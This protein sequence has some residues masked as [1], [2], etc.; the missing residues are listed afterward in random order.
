M[1]LFVGTGYLPMKIPNRA[2]L[3]YTSLTSKH[4]LY[5]DLW[6]IDFHQYGSV[7]VDR[8]RETLSAFFPTYRV[9]KNFW[10]LEILFYPV[11][12]LMRRHGVYPIHSGGVAHRGKGLVIAGGSGAGK[13]TLA[14]H[15]VR[16]G[17]EFLS[18]DRCL[19]HKENGHYQAVGIH[20]LARIYP[21]NVS[22]APEL[23]HLS[24]DFQENHGKKQYDILD[25][26]PDRTTSSVTVRK[27]IL[28]RWN[29]HGASRIRRISPREAAVQLFPQSVEI[30]F[31]ESA[32][33]QF[34]FVGELAERVPAFQM[35]LGDDR[36][37]WP[38]LVK[39]VMEED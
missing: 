15:L 5:D 6:L 2:R 28:P 39:E 18:D 1:G 29:G 37:R 27:I 11:F 21:E 13:S 14:V 17:F 19:L 38:D 25:L 4:Y 24:R 32:S 30:L 22:D 31:P 3:L 16:A 35:E 34:Q 26:Y 8:E 9:R 23:H 7:V 20:D 36:P 12:E 33:T 10:L